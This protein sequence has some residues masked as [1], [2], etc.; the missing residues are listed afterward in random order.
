MYFSNIVVYS[1]SYMTMG[2]EME[3]ALEIQLDDNEL[4]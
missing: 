2:F 4:N 3:L 1:P